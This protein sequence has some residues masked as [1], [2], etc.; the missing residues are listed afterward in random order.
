MKVRILDETHGQETS[1]SYTLEQ[2]VQFDADGDQALACL[3]VHYDSSGFTSSSAEI[4]MIDVEES[5]KRTDICVQEF[6]SRWWHTIPV[7]DGGENPVIPG[8]MLE[9]MQAVASRLIA[10]MNNV[11]D[12]DGEYNGED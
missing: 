4:F 5:G 9:P 8:A 3:T 2:Q 6:P 1:Y 12:P 11:L 7:I 10:R